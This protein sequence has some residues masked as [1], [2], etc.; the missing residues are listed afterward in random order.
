MRRQSVHASSPHPVPTA[1]RAKLRRPA[2]SNPSRVSGYRRRWNPNR[3]QR[4]TSYYKVGGHALPESVGVRLFV[5]IRLQQP[6][7]LFAGIAGTSWRCRRAPRPRRRTW[8]T[9]DNRGGGGGVPGRTAELPPAGAT[10]GVATR[11]HA[12]R[13]SRLR[14]STASRTARRPSS[15]VS[16]PPFERAYSVDSRG[17]C[18]GADR[19]RG[20]SGRVQAPG[21]ADGDERLATSPRS[22][23][24]RRA[25]V[26]AA[27]T[28]RSS[29]SRQ[30][31]RH[32]SRCRAGRPRARYGPRA[33]RVPSR[34]R[35]GGPS[36]CRRGRIEDVGRPRHRRPDRERA[37]GLLRL[38]E[39]A[40]GL[41]SARMAFTPLIRRRRA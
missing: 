21:T 40:W 7:K 24:P 8:A 26:G 6:P 3:G 19:S 2:S 33:C 34:G 23:D 11:S 39:P 16:H 5:S 13:P 9:T 15:T 30:R 28:P 4:R 22:L 20:R 32:R 27:P 38:D 12:V 29:P 14:S 18:A 17:A 31:G 25:V 10:R 35:R 1:G 37:G 41:R 36:R